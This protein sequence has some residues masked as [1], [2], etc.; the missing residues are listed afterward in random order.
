MDQ[1]KQNNS[2]VESTEGQYTRKTVWRNSETMQAERKGYYTFS[3]GIKKS[4]IDGESM[5][6]LH[7]TKTGILMRG[8]WYRKWETE[9]RKCRHEKVV[10]RRQSNNS[11]I[12]RC[13]SVI[14]ISTSQGSVQ[15]E[16]QIQ[17]VRRELERVIHGGTTKKVIVIGGGGIL[18]HRLAD[19]Y[20]TV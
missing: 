12:Q 2:N 8:K 16:Q 3:H 11:G 17:E 9:G 7:S 20:R 1:W 10:P 15:Y 4:E 14:G 19:I 18:M 13:S 5:Y 6:L